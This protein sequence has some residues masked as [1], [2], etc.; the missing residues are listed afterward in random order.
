VAIVW[1]SYTNNNSNGMRVGLD[2]SWSAVDS[3]STS[4]T[5][6]VAVWTQNTY[7]YNDGQSI[8]YTN[9]YTSTAMSSTAAT[10]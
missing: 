1:G 2:I 8:S 4:T 7:N 3:S 9:L 6:T 10:S 5:A